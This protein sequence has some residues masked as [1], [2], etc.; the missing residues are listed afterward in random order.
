MK[1]LIGTDTSINIRSV[2]QNT[3]DL[4][5]LLAVN[6]KKWMSKYLKKKKI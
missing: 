6:S 3:D 4:A 2:K 1:A 5:K